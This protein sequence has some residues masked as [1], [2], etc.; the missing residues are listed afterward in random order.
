MW[1]PYDIRASLKAD[2]PPEAIRQSL[3]DA[4][5]PVHLTAA[6]ADREVARG[7]FT[8]FEGA[9]LD[10]VIAKPLDIAYEPDKRLMFK[11]KHE[12]TAD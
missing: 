8:Q 9:G 1:I 2:S 4:E 5:P 11:L 6:T 12:R 10:G 7:W 3:A